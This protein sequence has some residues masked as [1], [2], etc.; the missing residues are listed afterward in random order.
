M[1]VIVDNIH[2]V[3]CEV[4]RFGSNLSSRII[5]FMNVMYDCLCYAP[6]LDPMRTTICL[7][8]N[9]LCTFSQLVTVC[10]HFLP[11]SEVMW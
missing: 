4:E 2:K 1:C 6:A 11:K 3:M 9:S 7:N 5:L 10:M 8:M